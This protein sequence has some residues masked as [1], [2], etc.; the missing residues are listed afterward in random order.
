[1]RLGSGNEYTSASLHLII[2]NALL[3]G[4]TLLLPRIGIDLVEICGLHYWKGSDFNPIQLVTYMFLHNPSSILHLVFNMFSLF[5]F[6]PVLE[7]AMG[8]KRFLFYYFFTGI[9][10]GIVQE[11]AW[12]YDLHGFT[13]EIASYMETGISGG[14]NVGNGTI[15]HSIGELSQFENTIYNQHITIGA[16]GAIF[17]LLLAFGMIF[18]NVPVY[19]FF[20]PIPV[21]AKYMVIAY[22]AFELFAGVNDFSFDKVAHFAHLGGMLFGIILLLFWRTQAKIRMQQNQERYG[23]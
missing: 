16:S 7:N 5:M 19:F 22:A 18:P 20:I 23:R 1:M 17:A 9:G 4:A 11:L 6:G 21:K 8:K 10:A 3:W 13:T 15:L 14:L 2:I 12:A